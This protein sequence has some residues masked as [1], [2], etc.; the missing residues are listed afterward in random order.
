MTRT[1][2]WL[3]PLDA[4]PA[5]TRRHWTATGT[6]VARTA[7]SVRVGLNGFRSGTRHQR[8]GSLH[9]DVDQG[10]L[11]AP[12]AA[13]PDLQARKRARLVTLADARRH[14]DLGLPSMRTS[15][16]PMPMFTSLETVS[17]RPRPG[18]PR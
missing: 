11:T 8:T 12:V 3:D 18:P 2:P 1:F 13:H 16:S 9:R 14:L 6:R 10:R 17:A 5:K 15:G 7:R 4:R